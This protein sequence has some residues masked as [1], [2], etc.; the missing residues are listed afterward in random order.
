L[1][2]LTLA[3]LHSL[4]GRALKAGGISHLQADAIADVVTAAERDECRSHGLHR[5]PGYV[6]TARSG[7]VDPQ[8]IPTVPERRGAVIRVDAGRGF[9]PLSVRTGRPVLI[10]AARESGIAALAISNC[11]HFSA[12]WCDIEPLADAGLA[13]IAFTIGQRRVALPG[14]K[15]PTLGTNPI[16]FAW[17]RTGVAPFVFDFAS[18]VV[19]RGEIELRAG[20]GE[21]L[22]VGWAIDTAGMPTTDS[23]SAL[24]GALLPFGGHKGAALAIM[25]ELLAG[26]LV[27]EIAAEVE[28]RGSNAPRLGGTLILGLDPARFDADAQD[29][30]ERTFAALLAD[31][32][33]RLPGERRRA[34][35]ARSIR[36]GVLVP[37]RL[38]REVTALAAGTQDGV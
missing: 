34:A 9:A 16:A 35:R 2:R 38:C 25:V 11:A 27:G 10:D 36:D 17:P 22:P 14:G 7:A 28:G 6:A 19:A 24:E 4:A 21:R 1:I 29:T 8:A 18:S 37:E 30:A 32:N 20:R 33:I 3:E 5:I 15:T 26:A 31:G 12:L 13:A 23:R